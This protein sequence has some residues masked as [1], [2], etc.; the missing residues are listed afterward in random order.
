M[1]AAERL[2]AER[3]AA[4]PL[5]DIALAAGQRNN[6]AVQYY[7]GS[8]DALI[9]AIV[10]HR[11]VGLEARRLELLA[12]RE[13]DGSPDD[14]RT[15]LGTLIE[16]MLEVPYQ[17]GST[18]YARFLEQVRGHPSLS[19]PANLV[20]HQRPAV[21]VI[22]GRLERALHDLPEAVRHRRLRSMPTVL[23]ALLADNERAAEDSGGDP[24]DRRAAAELVDLIT[25]VLTAP[26]SDRSL[27]AQP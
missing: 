15:L 13:A 6:S 9:A 14:V 11:L 1:L 4:A 16:P 7:F 5:R 12:E 2:I 17:Q 24:R 25:G 23:F 20:G 10:E 22:I 8:R 3:G 21:R 26:S 18:H 19:D 27:S